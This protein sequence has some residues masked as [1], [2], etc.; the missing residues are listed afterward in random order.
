M[1]SM[2]NGF[3]MMPGVPVLLE[4]SMELTFP[5]GVAAGNKNIYV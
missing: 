3:F 1:G 2:L 5:N 4:L